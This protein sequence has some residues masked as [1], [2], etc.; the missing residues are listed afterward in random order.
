MVSLGIARARTAWAGL[1]QRGATCH[2]D[3]GGFPVRDGFWVGCPL[4]SH[5][6]S[7]LPDPETMIEKLSADRRPRSATRQRA[8]LHAIRWNRRRQASLVIV[9]LRR[10]VRFVES[11]DGSSGA[12]KAA[13]SAGEERRPRPETR[14]AMLGIDDRTADAFVFASRNAAERPAA[15]R[16]RDRLL[17]IDVPSL[18]DPTRLDLSASVHRGCSEQRLV[19]PELLDAEFP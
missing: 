2:L 6:P 14:R 5:V 15:R 1:A 19:Y 4:A 12:T 17:R 16:N 7:S 18:C 3:S 10:A 9:R 13:S 8:E 11:F